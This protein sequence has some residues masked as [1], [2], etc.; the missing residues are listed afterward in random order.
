MHIQLSKR[1]LL[2]VATRM[3]GIAEKKSTMPIL[4]TTLLR[5]DGASVTMAATDL[6]QS[7][8]ASIP[9]EVTKPGAFAVSAK[10]LVDRAKVLPEGPIELSVQADSLTLKGKGSARRFTM[11]GM[12]GADYPPLPKYDASAPSLTLDVAVLSRLVALSAFCVSNDEARVHLNSLLIEWEGDVMRAVAADGHRLARVDMKVGGQTEKTLLLPLKGINEIKRLCEE[13][14]STPAE[15]SAG[16][17]LKVVHAGATAFF[18]GG[19]STF[20]VKLVD[21][22]F[23]PYRQVI[24]QAS[25]HVIRAPRTAMADAI[26][27]VSVAAEAKTNGVKLSVTKGHVRLASESAMAGDGVDELNVEYEGPNMST[28]F[29][30]KYL[31]DALSALSSEDVTIGLSAELEPIVIR[32]VGLEGI[33]VVYVVM[34]MR[35]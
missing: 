28:G 7:L 20:S 2:R 22:Q 27:A 15:D 3:A 6:Y 4:A 11:R 35:I 12:P 17:T 21:A 31:N 9:A 1:D 10:D 32:P 33:D 18:I 16:P 30:A 23:P 24:P 13:L 34:P 29:A 19:G 8:I 26:R 14:Y 5:A 25:P